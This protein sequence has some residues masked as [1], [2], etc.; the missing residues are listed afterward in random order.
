MFAHFG[1]TQVTQEHQNELEIRESLLVGFFLG[2]LVVLGGMQQWWLKMLLMSLS[3]NALYFGATAL[4]GITDNA[5]LTYL[6]SLVPNLSDS[7]KFLLVAGS[8]TGGGLTVIANAPNP[9]GYGILRNEFGED[10]IKP[11]GL[12]L[13]APTQTNR[14]ERQIFGKRQSF[15]LSHMVSPI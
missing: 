4:T 2:G 9:A 5:A 11:L 7:T 1:W 15:R 8:V 10:G 13:S 6:G 14:L 12:L 3:D